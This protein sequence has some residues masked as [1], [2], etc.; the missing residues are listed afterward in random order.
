MILDPSNQQKLGLANS[1]K[2]WLQTG[3]LTQLCG[4]RP[5]NLHLKLTITIQYNQLLKVTETRI[6]PTLKTPS[7]FDMC[8]V[9]YRK[10]ASLSFGNLIIPYLKLPS[11]YNKSPSNYNYNNSNYIVVIISTESVIA[12]SLYD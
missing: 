7:R 2:C 5:Y 9:C 11:F 8:Y 3:N 10:K 12:H 1:G 6:L 4:F